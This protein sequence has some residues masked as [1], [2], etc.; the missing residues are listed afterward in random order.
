MIEV[1][2][3]KFD[4]KCWVRINGERD[5]VIEFVVFLYLVMGSFF[6]KKD[7]VICIDGFV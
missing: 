4:G 2:E 1:S 5:I 7:I 6:V 3:R